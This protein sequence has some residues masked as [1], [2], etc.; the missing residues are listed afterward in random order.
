VAAGSRRFGVGVKEEAAGGCHV[1]WSVVS[2]FAEQRV[3]L[4]IDLL[5]V[6]TIVLH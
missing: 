5:R 4:I 6:L 3:T 2:S 1:T